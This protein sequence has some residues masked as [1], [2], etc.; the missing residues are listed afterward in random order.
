MTQGLRGK[1]RLEDET[2]PG[3]AGAA[4]LSCYSGLSIPGLDAVRHLIDILA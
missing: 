4:P 1:Q 2:N 3:D